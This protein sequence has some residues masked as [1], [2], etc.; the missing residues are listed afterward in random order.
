MRRGFILLFLVSFLLVIGC[1]KEEQATTTTLLEATEETTTTLQE[2]I[3]QETLE[4]KENIVE[5]TANGFNPG[6][7]TINKGEKITWV[8]KIDELSWPASAVHPSHTVYPGSDIKKCKTS[9]K[10]SIFD[11]CKGL[12][13]DESYSFI[14]G[15]TGKW[16]YHNHLNSD[17]TGI[18]IV[19]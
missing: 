15:E 12:K 9:E 7:L 17:I 1:E 3:T 6:S 2:T 5:I 16:A 13:L 11:A 10:D 18:V 14:F 19:Q 8:N 4:I